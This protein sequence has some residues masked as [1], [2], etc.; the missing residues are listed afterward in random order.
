M[1]TKE[2]TRRWKP[3]LAVGLVELLP[4]FL[5]PDAQSDEIGLKLLDL[6]LLADDLVLQVDCLLDASDIARLSWFGGFLGFL[7]CWIVQL[8]YA[9]YRHRTNETF[10]P[11]GS[12]ALFRSF[13]GF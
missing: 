1:L 5:L 10:N 4:F 8:R 13:N 6:Q 2:P 3:L 9:L 11:A 12:S 7:C